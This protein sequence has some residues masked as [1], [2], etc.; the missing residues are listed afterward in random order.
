[1]ALSH[2]WSDDEKSKDDVFS[3]ILKFKKPSLFL[4]QCIKPFPILTISY[5]WHG[6]KIRENDIISDPEKKGKRLKAL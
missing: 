2:F 6:K 3:W 4:F 1:M 5:S